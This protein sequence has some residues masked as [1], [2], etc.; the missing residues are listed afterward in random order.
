MYPA[1]FF[2]LKVSFNLAKTSLEEDFTFL[3]YL[4]TKCILYGAYGSARESP[5]IVCSQHIIMSVGTSW[6]H[7]RD[8]R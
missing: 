4:K 3:Y 1:V 5:K 7:F 8:C 2:I 6:L